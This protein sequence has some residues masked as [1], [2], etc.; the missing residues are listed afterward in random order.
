MLFRS[1]S[2]TPYVSA[3][4]YGFSDK[5]LRAADRFENPLG[6]EVTRYRRDAEGMTQ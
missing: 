5:P 4:S 6:F 1:V 3:I 2:S